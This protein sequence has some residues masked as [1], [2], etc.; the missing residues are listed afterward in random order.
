MIDRRGFIAATGATAIWP[1]TLKAQSRMPVIGFLNGQDAV[2]WQSQ[3]AGF[4]DGLR[5]AGF[6]DGQNVAIEYRWAEGKL[7]QLPDMAAQLAARPVDV[8]VASAGSQPALA[9]KAATSSVPI[10]FVLATDPVQ[11]GLVASLGRPGANITGL[12]LNSALIGPKRL[13]LLNEIKP[14]FQ[15]IGVLTNPANTAMAGAAEEL[16]VAGRKLGKRIQLF[17]ARDSNEIEA[18]FAAMTAAGV[19]AHIVVTDAMLS[20][21]R[22]RIVAFATLANMPGI[23]ENRQFATGGGLMSYGTDYRD[24]YR[25]AGRLTARILKGAKPAEIPV[26]QP[27]KFELVVNLKTAHT[28]G[29]TVPPSILIRADEVIE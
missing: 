2:G 18:A 19:D 7:G 12:T 13:E 8:I 20:A 14:S 26:E 22:A 4:S 6:V 9:A 15:V 24:T 29:I 10:V 17:A 3:L 16:A 21:N 23:Y 28:L 1:S 11:Q 5:E 27:T 25:Q